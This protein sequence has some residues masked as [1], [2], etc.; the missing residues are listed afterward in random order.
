M[1]FLSF[2]IRRKIERISTFRLLWDQE[3]TLGWI[4]LVVWCLTCDASYMLVN[5][6]LLTLFSGICEYHV[7]FNRTFGH[8]IE[9]LDESCVL[10]ENILILRKA[11]NFRVTVSK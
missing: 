5:T 9:K 10:A 7:G 3:T 8:I 11:I 4:G 6:A 2:S 1:F